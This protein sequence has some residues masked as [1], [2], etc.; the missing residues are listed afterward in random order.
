MPM[1][2]SKAVS[3]MNTNFEYKGRKVEIRYRKSNHTTRLYFFRI[4]G[5]H[6]FSAYASGPEQVEHAKQLIDNEAVQSR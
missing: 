4:D 1:K 5:K 3:V 6:A 2:P